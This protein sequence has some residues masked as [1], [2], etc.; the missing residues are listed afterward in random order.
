M[1]DE[2]S[3]MHNLAEGLVQESKKSL[4]MEVA[5][6][7]QNSQFDTER[8]ALRQRL[9]DEEIKSST[10]KSEVSRLSHQVEL[11]HQQLKASQSSQSNNQISASSHFNSQQIENI[12]SSPQVAASSYD[13]VSV[14]PNSSGI[15]HPSINVGLSPALQGYGQVSPNAVGGTR[16]PYKSSSPERDGL[17]KKSSHTSSLTGTIRRMPGNEGVRIGQMGAG[18]PPG[19]DRVN[20]DIGGA[21]GSGARVVN[22]PA[23]SQVNVTSHG[24]GKISLHVGATQDAAV[25]AQGRKSPYPMSHGSYGRGVPP[26]IPPN[27][28]HFASPPPGGMK[29]SPPPKTSS[30]TAQGRS[31]PSV[32]SQQQQGI[33]IPVTFLNNSPKPGVAGAASSSPV[34]NV[35]TQVQD[36]SPS[37]VRKS[38]QVCVNA[39]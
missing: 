7:K 3:R 2:K 12:S 21:G 13:S 6:E 39:K 15:L 20:P 11:L 18:V 31:S 29:P 30:L 9:Q 23:G 26:P 24:A 25:L 27:K 32:K 28:P 34:A 14:N 16:S 8:D 4:K 22:V 1:T 36:S 19:G 33:Q 5:L 35:R 38:S 10:L 17:K 37:A